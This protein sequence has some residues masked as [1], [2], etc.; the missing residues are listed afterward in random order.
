MRFGPTGFGIDHDW[1]EN[2]IEEGD[3]GQSAGIAAVQVFEAYG[4]EI[5]G[6][7]R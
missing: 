7:L 2:Q 6:Q 4:I 5:F 1:N 3:R